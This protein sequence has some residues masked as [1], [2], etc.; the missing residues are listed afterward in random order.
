[1]PLQPSNL[2]SLPKLCLKVLRGTDRTLIHYKCPRGAQS[3][4]V[5]RMHGMEAC[6]RWDVASLDCVMVHACWVLGVGNLEL[7]TN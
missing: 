5:G 1:M 4:L 2:V 6:K 7:D 3:D